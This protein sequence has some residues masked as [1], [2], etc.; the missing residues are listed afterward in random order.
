MMHKWIRLRYRFDVLR[1]KFDTPKLDLTE[2]PDGLLSANTNIK[3]THIRTLREDVTQEGGK[4]KPTTDLTKPFQKASI[5][6]WT[7]HVSSSWYWFLMSRCEHPLPVRPQLCLWCLNLVC[8][9]LVLAVSPHKTE[10]SGSIQRLRGIFFLS[11]FFLYFS[12]LPQCKD[13]KIALIRNA[14]SPL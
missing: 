10:L 8:M 12:F 2:K 5:T 1:W 9:V 4:G 14:E 6:G 3:Q 7:Q 11:F 13:L